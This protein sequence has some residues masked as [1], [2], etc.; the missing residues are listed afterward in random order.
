MSLTFDIQ[1]L[2]IKMSLWTMRGEKKCECISE[3]FIN[4]KRKFN[5]HLN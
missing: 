3:L 4:R 5:F 1:F 2:T